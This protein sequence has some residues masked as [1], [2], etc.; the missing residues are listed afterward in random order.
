MAVAVGV[1]VAV[2]V[3]VAVGVA[4]GLGVALGP[5]GVLV[6]NVKIVGCGVFVP[7]R[8]TCS[9]KL[10]PATGLGIVSTAVAAKPKMKK[11]PKI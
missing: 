4:L 1:A 10:C 9:A 11:K 8:V 3:K 5:L 6:A 7:G 2:S